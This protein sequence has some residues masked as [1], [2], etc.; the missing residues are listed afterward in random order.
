MPPAG[1]KQKDLTL[2]PFQVANALRAAG[3]YLRATVVWNK[4]RGIEPKRLDRPSVGHEY[5]FL[6]A[7]SEQYA[8]RDPGEAWWGQSVWAISPHASV[9]HPA[10]MPEEL[11]R[12][13][14]VAGSNP[15]DVILDPFAGS[16]TTVRVAN[17]LGRVGIGLD[18]SREY[19]AE[20]ALRR[21]DPLAAQERDVQRSGS[22][23]AVLL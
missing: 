4:M 21:I 17:R 8:A 18:I 22:G 9:E 19:L 16:G 3:W 12:R 23:Q 5:V 1:Y 2:V 20:Q 11:A 6:L 15:A 13:C 14:I 7:R 10:T